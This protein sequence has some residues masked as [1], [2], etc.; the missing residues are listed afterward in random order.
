MHAQLWNK[1]DYPAATASLD[2][3]HHILDSHW[4][5][6]PDSTEDSVDASEIKTRMES[7]SA[8]LASHFWNEEQLM[9]A[10]GY[11]GYQDHKAEHR[12]ISDAFEAL[13]T[14]IPAS[15]PRWTKVFTFLHQWTTDHRFSHDEVLDKFIKQSVS[16]NKIEIQ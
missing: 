1:R 4:G 9:C 14:I 2:R 8:L 16:S 13:L 12:R 6:I 5:S 11:P 7:M 10:V 15:A 3:E